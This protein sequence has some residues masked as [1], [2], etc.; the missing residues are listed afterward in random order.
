MV[1]NRNSA[2]ASTSLFIGQHSP[3]LYIIAS[4]SFGGS[5][6]HLHW[7]IGYDE[8]HPKILPLDLV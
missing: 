4:F 3:L 7:S 6:R 2:P 8:V 1:T 5:G